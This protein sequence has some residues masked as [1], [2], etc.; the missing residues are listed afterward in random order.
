MCNP[1]AKSGP[2]PLGSSVPQRSQH[3]QLVQKNVLIDM[4]VA[5]ASYTFTRLPE[6]TSPQPNCE[7]VTTSGAI[8]RAA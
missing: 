8:M 5:M 6:H 3:I 7:A 1:V 2:R 4:A